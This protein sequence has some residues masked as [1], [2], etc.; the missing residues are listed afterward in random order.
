MV[1]F[2]SALLCFVLQPIS[3]FFFF[4]ITATDQPPSE[5]SMNEKLSGMLHALAEL[6]KFI[7]TSSPSQPISC[8]LSAA[9][10][11]SGTMMTMIKV[12]NDQ[13]GRFHTRSDAIGKLAEVSATQ[14][15]Q[16]V[17]QDWFCAV[18]LVEEIQ[19]LK[20][21]RLLSDVS[22]GSLPSK[23]LLAF[24]RIQLCLHCMKSVG[25]QSYMLLN[26]NHTMATQEQ[27]LTGFQ[28]DTIEQLSKAH[29]I[30][31]ISVSNLPTMLIDYGEWVD[32][33]LIGVFADVTTIL[34]GFQKH[35]DTHDPKAL[36]TKKKGMEEKMKGMKNKG[37][38]EAFMSNELGTVK[39][40]WER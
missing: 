1:V 29:D 38:L 33:D 22:V 9:T 36:I 32:K 19:R 8:H 2:A 20:Y 37:E 7:T 3:C 31:T 27:Y 40:S 28:V 14:A 10:A 21:D 13:G 18:E 11:L 39:T 16:T 30:A 6:Q 35:I 34:D 24:Y 5:D 26:E 12:A 4:I 25:R 17:C 23:Q 15:V